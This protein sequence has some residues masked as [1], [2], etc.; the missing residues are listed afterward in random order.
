MKPWRDEEPKDYTKKRPK[1]ANNRPGE[2]MRVINSYV[3]D[4]E[5][6]DED[7][8]DIEAHYLYN[9]KTKPSIHRS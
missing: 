8:V 2:G 7:E 3:E 9:K 4:D 1:R 5:F 6:Y